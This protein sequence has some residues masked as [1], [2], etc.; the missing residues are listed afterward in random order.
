MSDK[1]TEDARD[2]RSGSGSPSSTGMQ[3]TTSRALEERLVAGRRQLCRGLPGAD[4]EFRCHCFRL[5]SEHQDSN[6]S[7]CKREKLVGQDYINSLYLQVQAVEKGVAMVEKLNDFSTLENELTQVRTEMGQFENDA[8]KFAGKA[9]AALAASTA[10]KEKLQAL[11]DS[12]VENMARVISYLHSNFTGAADGSLDLQTAVDEFA[13]IDLHFSKA[14]A[15][16]KTDTFAFPVTKPPATKSDPTKKK[17]TSVHFTPSRPDAT[18]PSPPPNPPSSYT[19]PSYFVI[20]GPSTISSSTT[21]TMTSTTTTDNP[22]SSD[23]KTH[24]SNGFF[25]GSTKASD[26]SDAEGYGGEDVSTGNDTD[27]DTDVDQVDAG[28][29]GLDEPRPGRIIIH[30]KH[31]SLCGGTPQSSKCKQSK[32][33]ITVT[34]K[35]SDSPTEH[36]QKEKTLLMQMSSHFSRDTMYTL[37]DILIKRATEIYSY[38]EPMLAITSHYTSFR[39]FM[40]DLRRRRFPNVQTACLTEFIE[41]KQEGTAYELY[42]T[43]LNLL[44][45]MN[46]EPNQYTNE[47]IQKLKHNEVKKA[48]LMSNYDGLDLYEMAKHA[49][50]VERTMGLIATNKGNKGKNGDVNI[51]SNTKTRAN[52]GKNQKGGEKGKSAGRGGRGGGR[53]RG[54]ARGGGNGSGESRGKDASHNHD[55]DKANVSANTT[56]AQERLEELK[57]RSSKQMNDWGIENNCYGCLQSGHPYRRK[58]PM[59]NSRR[60][61]FCGKDFTAPKGHASVS[62]NLRPKTKDELKKF[63]EDAKSKGTK[64]KRLSSV[65]FDDS[66]KDTTD[67][68]TSDSE[69]SE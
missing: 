11:F 52:G 35:A 6:M 54:R 26:D 17:R 31:G 34:F 65:R 66:G 67:N 20:K 21:T 27:A 47:F 68:G 45:A 56:T 29:P 10:E 15:A 22:S 49:D 13:R 50:K 3:P 8:K 69:D 57:K 58:E 64:P 39:A 9:N 46:R 60:C 55:G 51:S 37:I 36:M 16:P 23:S 61:L 14:Q 2:D 44:R 1:N 33:H 41:L 18:P 38:I 5:Q 43:M 25:S 48:L 28:P 19:T 53:G 24:I 40:I 4:V 12:E 59:C 42:Q 7:G 63:W 32:Y 30:E 62:C